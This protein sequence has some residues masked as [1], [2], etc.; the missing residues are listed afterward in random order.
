MFKELSMSNG[1]SEPLSSDPENTSQYIPQLISIQ[2][3]NTAEREIKDS[4]SLKLKLE[5][6]FK[7]TENIDK[8][9]RKHLDKITA[10]KPEEQ[11]IIYSLYN[12]ILVRELDSHEKE[13]LLE[14]IKSPTCFIGFKAPLELFSASITYPTQTTAP[15]ERWLNT[16]VV[17]YMNTVVTKIVGD[18]NEHVFFNAPDPIILS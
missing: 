13:E 16:Q 14:I 17:N 3:L 5:S 6:V 7:D 9:V 15:F 18:I 4:E 11:N 10:Y 8:I 12:A 1:V 2:N